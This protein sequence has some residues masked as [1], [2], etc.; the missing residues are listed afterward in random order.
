MLGKI[1]RIVVVIDALS[2]PSD[3]DDCWE[4]GQM[5]CGDEEVHLIC[6]HNSN[7]NGF[8][9]DTAINNNNNTTMISMAP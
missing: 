5:P 6:E 3:I 2:S 1:G 7:V 8:T 9:S 4:E